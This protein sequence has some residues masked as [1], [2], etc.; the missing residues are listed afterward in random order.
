SSLLAVF[1]AAILLEPNS[2][3]EYER[4][5]VDQRISS[6]TAV[7]SPGV[8]L[9]DFS[10]SYSGLH[11]TQSQFTIETDDTFQLFLQY[12]R[13]PTEVVDDQKAQQDVAI[14]EE[15]DRLLNSFNIWRI[16]KQPKSS[17]SLQEV[18]HN[19]EEYNQFS[20]RDMSSIFVPPHQDV[21]TLENLGQTESSEVLT[22]S[23]ADEEH[24]A[25]MQKEK[26]Q[27]IHELQM[28]PHV[29]VPE[30]HGSTCEIMGYSDNGIY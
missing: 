25:P 20:G 12:S 15:T 28:L 26:K 4:S 8:S 30:T 18:V 11:I 13:T 3:S 7:L 14:A 23:S 21:P 27:M 29:P 22:T 16:N 2:G 9:L 24:E 1:R 5:N 19:P 17:L 10:Q 6:H